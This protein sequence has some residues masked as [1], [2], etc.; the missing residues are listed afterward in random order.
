MSSDRLK[1]EWDPDL[2]IA[3]FSSTVRDAAMMAERLLSVLR[4][5]KNVE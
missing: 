5:G 2:L 4:N 1:I 3:S